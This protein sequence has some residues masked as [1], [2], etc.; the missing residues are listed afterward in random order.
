MMVFVKVLKS[1]KWMGILTSPATN[2]IS[3]YEVDVASCKSSKDFLKQRFTD[4]LNANPWLCSRLVKCKVDGVKDVYLSFPEKVSDP[5]QYILFQVN[6]VVFQLKTISEA[7]NILDG[8]VKTGDK[9]INK[10]ERL[11]YLQ[12]MEN[13]AQTKL[14]VLFSLSHNLGDGHT[15]YNIWKMLDMNETV[16]KFEVERILA[17]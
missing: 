6:D 2:L 10:D 8:G 1:E 3:I 9:C 14:A 13:S 15:C 12:V 4:I 11:C 17:L 7:W 5:Y 16:R